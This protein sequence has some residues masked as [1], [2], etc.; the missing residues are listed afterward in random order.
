MF[1]INEF[2]YKIGNEKRI[3]DFSTTNKNNN[4][5]FISLIISPNGTGTSI[6]L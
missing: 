2:T 4:L 5:L 1:R 3:I 6:I